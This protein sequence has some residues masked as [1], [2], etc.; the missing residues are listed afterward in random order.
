MPSAVNGQPTFSFMAQM[1]LGRAGAVILAASVI[2]N[3]SQT[4]GNVTTELST[5]DIGYTDSNQIVLV[6]IKL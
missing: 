2:V 5:K 1:I 6:R 4:L 3:F